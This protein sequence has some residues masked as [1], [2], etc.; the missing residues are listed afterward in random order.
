MP[1]SALVSIIK[2]R[3]EEIFEHIRDRLQKAGVGPMKGRRV[4]LTG[5]ASQLGGVREVAAVLLGKNVRLGKPFLLASTE[6][7]QNPAFSTCVGLLAYGQ[8]EHLAHL[9]A[10]PPRRFFS[11]TT[12]FLKKIW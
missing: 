11:K 1:R 9:Q 2:P 8:A 12:T 5:G 10:L 7:A 3:I 6:L 4:V